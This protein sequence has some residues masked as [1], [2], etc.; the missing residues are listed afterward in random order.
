MGGGL[1]GRKIVKYV[2]ATDSGGVPGFNLLF[3]RLVELAD[4]LFFAEHAELAGALESAGTL[5]ERRKLERHKPGFATITGGGLNVSVGVFFRLPETSPGRPGVIKRQV[6]GKDLQQLAAGMHL[7]KAGGEKGSG[8]RR[9]LQEFRQGR[10][11]AAAAARQA[12]RLDVKDVK[13]QIAFERHLLFTGCRER[14]K[15]HQDF[16]GEENQ[17]VNLLVSTS[18][19]GAS[20]CPKPRGRPAGFRAASGGGALGS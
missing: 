18:R 9:S 7:G 15:S 1:D 10:E 3:N 16:S 5:R 12:A 14:K 20:F 13:R 17:R 6:A 4:R 19:E 2:P 11:A 8:I